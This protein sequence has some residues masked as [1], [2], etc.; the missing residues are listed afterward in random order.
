MV[1]REGIQTMASGAAGV[2]WQRSDASTARSAPQP[3]GLSL[4]HHAHIGVDVA[5]REGPRP[6][7]G[8]AVQQLAWCLAGQACSPS[9]DAAAAWRRLPAPAA[10]C[11]G[12]RRCCRGCGTT[13]VFSGAAGS[14]RGCGAQACSRSAQAGGGPP[15]GPHRARVLA[16]EMMA[17][18]GR[19]GSFMALASHLDVESPASG[20]HH[21]PSP[22]PPISARASSLLQT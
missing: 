4:Y 9:A 22:A 10:A 12:W 21:S 18:A 7:G 11:R 20:R 6:P 3:C 19:P 5:A 1:E 17:Y 8:R 2:A 16:H 15:A 13:A 14:K